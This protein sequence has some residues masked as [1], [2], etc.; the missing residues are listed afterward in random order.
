MTAQFIPDVFE[1]LMPSV[2]QKYGS[3]VYYEYGHYREIVKNLTLKEGNVEK[4]KKYPLVWLVM[5]FE[6]KHGQAL[7]VY[8]SSKFN[9][10]IAMDSTA[11]RTMKQRRD[12]VYV[13][14]LLPIY[15]ALIDSILESPDIKTLGTDLKHTSILRPYWGKQD[16]F[17]NGEVNLFND[18]VD[19]IQ[20]K[21]LELNIK[22]ICIKQPKK[23]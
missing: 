12:E 2:I 10:I 4:P 9:I 11:N 17:G 7:S 15:E 13:T 3:T 20:I 8:A 16:Q 5:D 1:K 23:I 21:D 19:A 14:V 18:I 6:E 22:D